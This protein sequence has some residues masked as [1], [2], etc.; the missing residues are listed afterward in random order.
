MCIIIFSVTGYRH[1]ILSPGLICSQ[2]WKYEAT[3]LGQKI[4]TIE[5]YRR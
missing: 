5:E 1:I 2:N 4:D 3:T